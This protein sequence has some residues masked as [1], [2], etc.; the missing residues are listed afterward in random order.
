MPE[1]LVKSTVQIHRDG[2]IVQ[3]EIGKPFKFTA[4]E[5]EEVKKIN[6]KALA[7]IEKK[8]E[9]KPAVEKT[10]KAE[11]SAKAG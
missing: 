8:P 5:V 11:P 3:P 9:E 1:R 2:Q 10:P 4:E 6:P 7:I